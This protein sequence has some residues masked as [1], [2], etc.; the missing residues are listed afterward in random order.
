MLNIEIKSPMGEQKFRIVSLIDEAKK[1][2]DHFRV[3]TALAKVEILLNHDMYGMRI[4][5]ANCK[6][7]AN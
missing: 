7:E 2:V 1:V 6:A 5:A 4:K 3:P